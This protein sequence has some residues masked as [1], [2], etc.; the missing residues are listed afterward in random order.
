MTDEKKKPRKR[1]QR[2]V[3]KKKVKGNGN[4]VRDT[5]TNAIVNTNRSALEAAKKAKMT[6][7][8]NQESEQRIANLE[9]K[10]DTVTKQLEQ[11]LNTIE[12]NNK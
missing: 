10:L 5:G 6:A 8:K 3:A 11:L 12:G 2:R 1:R 7:L 4:L 9:D